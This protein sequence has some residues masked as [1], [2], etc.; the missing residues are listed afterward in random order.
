MAASPW[1]S[2]GVLKALL[3]SS[4]TESN[5]KYVLGANAPL[6][7][8]I[9]AQAAT[10]LT[11]QGYMYLVGLNATNQMPARDSI[12]GKMLSLI[13]YKEALLRYVVDSLVEVEEFN[14]ADDLLIDDGGQFARETRV[15]LQILQGNLSGQRAS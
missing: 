15:G 11:A 6:P 2:D 1:L 10:V 14:E 4:M 13:N 3:A 5:K 7:S 9:M 8:H 12:R